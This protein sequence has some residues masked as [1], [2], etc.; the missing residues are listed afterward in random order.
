LPEASTDVRAAT[1]RADRHLTHRYDAVRLGVRPGRRLLGEETDV[2]ERILKS[3]ASGYWVPAARIEHCIRQDMQTVTY[4][5]RYFVGSGETGAFRNRETGIA[6]PLWFEVP[7]W[8]W[9]RLILE[10]LGYR[11]HRL[12]SPAP[13]WVRHLREYAV[14]WGAIRYWRHQRG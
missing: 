3:G 14:A 1:R 13:V 11:F 10:W 2:L 12:A 6:A 4:I 8:L 9:R 7:R 5:A